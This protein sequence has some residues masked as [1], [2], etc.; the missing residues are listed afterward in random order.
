MPL[1]F[2]TDSYAP[3]L[4]A[5][6]VGIIGLA[7]WLVF[8]PAASTTLGRFPVQP[9]RLTWPMFFIAA[10]GGVLWSAYAIRMASDFWSGER[11]TGVVDVISGQ[12][13]AALALAGLP[14]AVALGWLPVRLP[15]W[16]GATL[17]AGFGWFGL[18]NPDEVISPGAG[19]DVAAIVWAGTVLLISEVTLRRRLHA[20]G[21]RPNEQQVP[22]AALGGD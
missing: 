19:W 3:G 14:L 11:Y 16:T 9:S 20:A 6:L 7:G 13:G 18:R 5:T 22:P 15:M 1:L 10:L 12:A 2:G 17:G 21:T 8:A 4:V